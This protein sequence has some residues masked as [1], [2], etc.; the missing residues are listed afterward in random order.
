MPPINLRWL[1]VDE[2]DGLI[3]RRLTA[4]TVGGES[5]N[6]RVVTYTSDVRGAGTDANVYCYLAGERE[7]GKEIWGPMMKL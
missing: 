1:A 6:Y 3:R 4:M 7:P 5:T 2:D